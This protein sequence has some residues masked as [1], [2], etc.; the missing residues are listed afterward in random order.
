MKTKTKDF[1][2]YLLIATFAVALITIITTKAYARPWQPGGPFYT[3]EI[4]ESGESRETA[5]VKTQGAK[6]G[7][8]GVGSW[9]DYT[10][11]GIEW[12]KTHRTCASRDLPRYSY[13]RITN[14]ANGK[15][16][17]CFVNDYG[18]EAWTGREIDLSRYAFSQIADLGTGLINVKIEQ[19]N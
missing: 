15:S 5:S 8:V 4:K 2:I 19:S 11:N 10:I 6:T 9:Y 3:P 17:E 18:P 7:V 14:L 12:S 13:A 1:Q 16:V